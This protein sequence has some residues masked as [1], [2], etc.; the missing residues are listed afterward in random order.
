MADD[1]IVDFAKRAKQITEKKVERVEQDPLKAFFQDNDI[2]DIVMAGL[3]FIRQT[4]ISDTVDIKI[5]GDELHL[6]VRNMVEYEDVGIDQETILLKKASM[7]LVDED[8]ED[9]PDEILVENLQRCLEAVMTPMDDE[10]EP[11]EP[12]EHS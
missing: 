1:N 10:D 3:M 2:M 9:L 11:E 6:E 4:S 8:G 7:M 5:D 12:D